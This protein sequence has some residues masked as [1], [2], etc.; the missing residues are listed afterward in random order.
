MEVKGDS[1]SRESITFSEKY[2]FIIPKGSFYC[3]LCFLCY[4]FP[5]LDGT[6]E[7][8]DAVN[9]SY[10]ICLILTK[11]IILLDVICV[12]VY[13]WRWML[14]IWYHS[15][16]LDGRFFSFLLRHLN[17]IGYNFYL[18]WLFTKQVKKL[19]AELVCLKYV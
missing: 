8:K 3:S 6:S 17:W 18:L 9:H 1:D 7:T 12:H 15:S 19:S 11:S 14:W 4:C 5:E 10:K 13:I 2:N 16:H